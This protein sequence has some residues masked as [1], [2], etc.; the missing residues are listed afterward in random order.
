M[1]RLFVA[2]AVVC[3]L[4]SPAVPANLDGTAI[5]NA[6]FRGKPPA[7]DKADAVIVKVQILLGRALFSPGEIDGKLTENTQ[8]ALRAFADAKSLTFPKTITP[9]PWTTLTQTG[10]DPVI[11]QSTIAAGD[12][13][14]PFLRKLPPNMPDITHLTASTHH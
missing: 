11:T 14:G 4:S 7:E 6:E 10:Q 5:N 1:A 8:K 13:K 12:V 3:L 2:A 9:E